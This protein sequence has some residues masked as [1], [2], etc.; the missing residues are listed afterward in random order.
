L[1]GAPY[2]SSG[3]TPACFDCSGFVS[4]CYAQAGI[5]LPRRAE[6]IFKLG[7]PVAIDSC[8]PGDLVFFRTAGKNVSHIGIMTDSK[9]FIHASTSKGVVIT[10]LTDGYWAPRFIGMKRLVEKK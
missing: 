2:C 7:G 6:D 3:G 10:P 8:K 9:N 1:L 5:I 4:Y